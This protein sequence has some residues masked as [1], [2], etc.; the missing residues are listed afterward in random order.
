MTKTNMAKLKKM[1]AQGKKISMLTCYDYSTAVLLS[2]AGVDS[3]LVGDTLGQV[4]L[5]YDNTLS[6]DMDTIITF[7]KAVRRGAP[8]VFLLGDMPFMSYHASEESAVLNAGRFMSEA[9]C[10]AVKLEVTGKYCK[11]VE[12]ICD[13]GIP[14]IAHLGFLPQTIAGVDKIVA[15]REPGPAVTLLEDCKKMIDCGVSGLLLEC[16]TSEVAAEITAMTELPVISCGS[17]PHCDGQVIV[18]HEMLGMPGAVNPVFVKQYADAAELIRNAAAKYA[19]EIKAQTFPTEDHSYH[20]AA[21]KLEQFKSSI[22]QVR[23]DI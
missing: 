15:T 22:N 5:G 1:K 9:G 10:D 17:G 7:T 4:M 8:E 18:L 6:V 13:A 23:E 11:T 19:E 14:V 2:Q 16:V 21:K 12:K 3:L 20:I